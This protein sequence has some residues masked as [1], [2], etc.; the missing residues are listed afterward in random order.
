MIIFL[1]GDSIMEV[2]E[3]YLEATLKLEPG[4]F[5]CPVVWVTHFR[6]HHRLTTLYPSTT[7]S[8]GCLFIHSYLKIE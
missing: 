1:E 2:Q 8:Q 6:L 4:A 7:K 5:N 3:K